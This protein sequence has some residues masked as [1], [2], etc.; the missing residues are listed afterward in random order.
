V[1]YFFKILAIFFSSVNL[2]Y[3]QEI[4]IKS[5][6]LFDLKSGTKKLIFDI[7]DEIVLSFDHLTSRAQSFY[8][9][10]EHND[11]MWSKSKIRKNEF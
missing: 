5:I 9:E 11:Y 2:I 4:N 1:N 3:S 7:N 8:L 6:E 10:I